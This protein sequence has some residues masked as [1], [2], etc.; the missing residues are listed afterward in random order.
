MLKTRTDVWCWALLGSLGLLPGCGGQSASNDDDDAAGGGGHPSPT[1]GG[2]G[3]LQSEPVDGG[4][5]SLPTHPA[6]FGGNSSGGTAVQPSA[7]NAGQPTPVSCKGSIA[8]VESGVETGLWRCEDGVVHRPAP[9]KCESN[10]PRRGTAPIFV[11][12]LPDPLPAAWCRT[13]S[14]CTEKPYGYCGPVGQISHFC[15]YGCVSDSDC[16]AGNVCV[17]GPEF[18]IC[19]QATCQSDADCGGE[20]KCA[21]WTPYV[22]IGCGESPAY[23][24]QSS[25]D[26]CKTDGECGQGDFCGVTNG[27]RA[28]Q[29]V[30]GTACGRPFIVDGQERLACAQT[31]GAWR[32]KM[33]ASPALSEL[34]ARQRA[35][36]GDEWTKMGLMEHASV[37]A[38]ARFAL[39]LLHVG[40]PRELLVACQQAMADET[41]HARLCFELA[42][43]YLDRDIGPGVLPVDAALAGT[44]LERIVRLVMREGCIGETIAAQEAAEAAACAEDVAVLSVLER[45]HRDERAHAELAWRFVAWAL[46]RGVANVRAVVADE[47]WLVARELQRG[48]EAGQGPQA[49]DLVL[50]HHGILNAPT[51]AELRRAVL[52]DIVLPCAERLLAQT[53]PPAVSAPNV[54]A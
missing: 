49:D 50:S 1:R 39:Q 24:C 44:N 47:L 40:A 6:G 2:G 32:G 36:L 3:M 51:R 22:G 30:P 11:P 21:A 5:T 27:V 48:V 31:S 18:G 9:V 13:D 52:T 16:G 45:I 25:R 4:S 28:C 54:D 8:V 7:G 34:S 14:D 20:F 23:A 37:A 15:S 10:L 38:F 33:A 12:P 42:S 17:C 35:R 26:S 29:R 46:T 53:A 43:V 19:A 41:E